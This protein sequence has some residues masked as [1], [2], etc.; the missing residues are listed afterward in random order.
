MGVEA[1]YPMQ[2]LAS[3][4]GLI[5]GLSLIAAIIPG[6]RASRVAPSQ[7]LRYTG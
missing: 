6:L 7:A 5:V 1:N 2:T 3:F 4:A